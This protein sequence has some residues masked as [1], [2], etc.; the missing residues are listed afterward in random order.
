MSTKTGAV[1]R[2]TEDP[3]DDFDPGFTRDGKHLIFSSSRSGHF[4]IWIAERDGSGARRITNDGVDAENPVS[5]PDDQWIVYASG[6]PEKRGIW[7]VRIDGSAASRLVGGTA[8]LPELSPDGRFVSYM[9]AAEAERTI[10]VVRFED[11]APVPFELVAPGAR[12]NTGRHRWMPDGRAFVFQT[13]NEKGDLGIAT[14]DFVPGKDTAASRRFVTGFTPDT[15]TETLGVS[16]DGKRLT[17]SVLQ[18]SASLLLV[19]GVEGVVAPRSSGTA[20]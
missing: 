12:P 6:S 3:A 2:L 20:R 17:V 14:Q 10:R 15:W 7:K 8:T 11:G 13:E 5:T 1:R 16:P 9:A 18:D 4:E 19:E